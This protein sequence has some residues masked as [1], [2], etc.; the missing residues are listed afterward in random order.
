[1]ATF[2]TLTIARNLTDAGA[3]PKLAAAIT[4]AV[5]QTAEHDNAAEPPPERLTIPL[6]YTGPDAHKRSVFKPA[7]EHHGCSVLIQPTFAERFLRDV[8]LQKARVTL[9]VERD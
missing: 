8:D 2:D 1:M 7:D 5:R 4:A 9:V 6:D 3:D